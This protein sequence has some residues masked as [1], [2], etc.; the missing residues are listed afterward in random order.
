M[1]KIK[2]SLLITLLS[3]LAGSVEALDVLVEF[4]TAAFCHTSKTFRK[5]YG[6]I[7]PAFQ[8]EARTPIYCPFEGWVNIDWFHKD[9]DHNSY[10]KSSVNIANA[11]FGVIWVYSPLPSWSYYFGIGPSVGGIFLQNKSVD[12]K[13]NTSKFLIGGVL[14]NG[15]TYRFSNGIFVDAFIDYLY[16]P[17]HFN[18]TNDVGGVKLGLGLGYAF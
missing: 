4:R 16:Q 8:I 7:G 13:D 15:I 5:L 2:L 18:K 3:L 10:L 6:D 14:K 12:Y 17:V 11:S 1:N 9:K